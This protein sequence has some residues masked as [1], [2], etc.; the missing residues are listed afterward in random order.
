[1]VLAPQMEA[2]Q[3][4]ASRRSKLLV[5]ALISSTRATR[6]TPSITL[7]AGRRWMRGRRRCFHRSTSMSGCAAPS[8]SCTT[9]KASTGLMTPLQTSP[10]G[11]PPATAITSLIVQHTT[12]PRSLLLLGSHGPES[13]E[14]GECCDCCLYGGGPEKEQPLPRSRHA[15]HARTHMHTHTHAHAHTHAHT[16]MHIHTYTHTNIGWSDVIKRDD[17]RRTTHACWHLLQTT[18][19]SPTRAATLVL[20]SIP[21][22]NTFH[23]STESTTSCCCCSWTIGRVCVCV[24]SVALL[25]T[26]LVVAFLVVCRF[27]HWHLTNT[28]THARTHARTHAHTYTHTHTHH[29]APV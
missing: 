27:L 10:R 28:H 17:P 3:D 14:A 22:W 8:W 13:R 20:Q 6:L 24:F 19:S 18:A 9:S 7:C 2:P 26:S 23:M 11:L 15:T 5:A 29:L 1:M 25:M 16:H 12:W 4:F 21:W